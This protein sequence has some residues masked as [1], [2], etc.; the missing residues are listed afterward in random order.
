VAT[1]AAAADTLV[2]TVRWTLPADDGKGPLDSLKVAMPNLIG[3]SLV[4]VFL[5]GVGGLPTQAVFRQPLPYRDASYT[6]VGQVC[7]FR[8]TGSNAITCVTAS[9][10]PFQYA[11]VAPPPVTGVSV[12]NVQVPPE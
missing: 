7:V 12:T 4:Q 2:T 3:G 10:P 11:M 8:G 5:P 6:M 1:A 9:A